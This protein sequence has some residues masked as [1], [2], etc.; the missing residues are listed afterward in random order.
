LDVETASSTRE[1]LSFAFSSSDLDAGRF[2]RVAQKF[3]ASR[4]ERPN[5]LGE[6]GRPSIGDDIRRLKPLQ[7]AVPNA[8]Q[9]RELGGGN[10][11]QGSRGTNLGT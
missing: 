6:D 7:R 11:D 10:S 8:C 3:N 1:Q 4:F 9:A 2:D 5:D